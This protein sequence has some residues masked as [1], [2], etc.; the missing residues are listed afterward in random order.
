MAVLNSRVPCLRCLGKLAP[1]P[2]GDTQERAR[3]PP[4]GD[5]LAGR[6]DL[7]GARSPGMGT[8]VSE[9]HFRAYALLPGQLVS[10]GGGGCVLEGE[11]YGLE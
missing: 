2:G 5:P 4:L 8:V 9:G 1:K 7:A 11:P 3:V 10:L 6:E